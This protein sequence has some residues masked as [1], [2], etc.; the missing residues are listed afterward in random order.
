MAEAISTEDVIL[1][2]VRVLTVPSAY[3]YESHKCFGYAKKST[4]SAGVVAEGIQA[5]K[6]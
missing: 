6:E 5:T 2:T 3:S 1:E 4:A